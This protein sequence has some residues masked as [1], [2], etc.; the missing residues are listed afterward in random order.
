MHLLAEP[1]ERHGERQA[2][3]AIESATS[4][5]YHHRGGVPQTGEQ[6]RFDQ[7]KQGHPAMMAA[8]APSCQL[9]QVLT[10]LAPVGL[11]DI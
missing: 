2:A 7:A 1:F 5:R 10:G 3:I 8:P 4:P 6:G 9:P 11:L